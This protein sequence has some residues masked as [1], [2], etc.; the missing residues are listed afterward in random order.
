MDKVEPTINLDGY[1]TF[2]FNIE[3]ENKI[4]GD[5]NN[6]G[7]IDVADIAAIVS[8]MAGETYYPMADVNGDGVTDVADIATVISIMSELARQ[9]IIME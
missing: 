4:E 7:V 5:V 8:V 6:D 9:Q 1:N 3:V 2:S